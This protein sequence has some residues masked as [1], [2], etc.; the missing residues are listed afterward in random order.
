M[1]TR[2]ASQPANRSGRS[3]A[4]DA[5]PV[6]ASKI[7]VPAVPEW[8]VPRSRV[9]KLIAGGTRWCPLTVLT[10]PA[11]AGKTMALAGWAAAEPGP[12]AWVTV[13]EYDRRPGLFW[14]YVVA[15]LRRSG[16]AMPSGLSATPR[17]RAGDEGFSLQLAAVLAAQ[18]PPVTLV[19]DDLHLLAEPGMLK[20][21]DFVLRNVGPGLR[22]VVASRIDPLLSLHRWRLAGQLTEVRSGDLAFST[23]EASL[24]LARHGIALPPDLVERLT[25]RTEGWAA[26]LRL[27]ALS[28]NARPDPGQFVQELAM[29][30]SSLTDYLMTEVLNTQPPQVRDMLLCTSILEQVSAEAAAE[31]AG[32]EQAAGILIAL[33]RSNAFIQ[34]AGSGWYRY[35]TLFAE[36][37]RLKLQHEYPDRVAALHRRAARWYA[38]NGLLADAVRHAARAGDW[39]LAATLVIDDLAVGQ[40]LAPRGDQALAE[41]FASMPPGQ[42]WTEPEPYLVRAA[43]ELSAGQTESCAAALDAADGLLERVRADHQAAVRLAA[44]L[45]HL[46]ASLR[47]GDLAVAAAAA[48]RAELLVSQVPAGK[49]DRHPGISLRV[50]SGRAAVELWSGRPDEAVR[51]LQAGLAARAAS[52]R[53][54]EPADGYGLLAL[55]EALRGRLRRAA[56][57]ATGAIAT[58]TGSPP[59]DHHPDP[60]ALVALAWVHLERNELRQA[61]HYLKRADT[62]LSVSPDQLVGAVAYLVAAGGALAEGRAAVAAQV[63]TRARSRSPVPAWLNRKLD[64]IQSRACAAVGDTPAAL[65]AAGRAGAEDAAEAA[66]TR[67]HAWAAAGD[68]DSA[69]RALT[70]ALAAGSGTSSQVRMQALLIDARL[71][72]AHGDQTRGHWSLSSALQLAEPEQLRLPLAMERSWIEPALRDEPELASAHRR[73]L[74]PALPPEPPPTPRGAPDQATIQIVEP[75]SEREREV[76]RHVSALLNTAEVASKMY[77]SANTVK[78]HLRNI[79][80]KLAA[81]HRSEAVRRARQLGLI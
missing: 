80:R 3:P 14:S 9:T 25:R 40:V 46:A 42:A 1:K 12:V 79:Y 28:M 54:D 56:E 57:L 11:G 61:R 8:A 21:L 72:Y 76:L 64:L 62:A 27:A 13:D 32:D 37:L 81:N 66:V 53:D 29:E 17:E 23:A 52:V 43:A 38:R 35:H 44:A 6:L 71:C 47:T 63:I 15:A 60:A 7:T 67:A 77:I 5:H 50:M 31:L 58:V 78:T 18:D 55:A 30:N 68:L 10:G 73:L 69:R 59:P 45:I 41:E 48:T 4:P 22:L 16:V 2:V 49:L 19:L 36:V 70:P 51:V 24:L 65:A 20:G 34:P 39:P 75:L 33:A 26:G 74:G